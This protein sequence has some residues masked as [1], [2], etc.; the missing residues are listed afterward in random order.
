[1]KLRNLFGI[2]IIMISL[3]LSAQTSG[4]ITIEKKGMRKSYVQNNKAL[5]SKQLASV[6][7]SNQSSARELKASKTNSI[8]GLSSMACGTIFIGVGFYNTIKAAQATNDNDLVG[9]TDYSNKSAGDMLIG[10]GFYVV[11]L[12]FI[13]MSNSHL[14]KSINLYNSANKTGSI[15]KI[16]MNFGFTGTRAMVQLRF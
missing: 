1:M 2:I 6:L 14:K 16:D 3:N 11:S 8:I 15:N 13:I 7:N 10:A 9:S 12:P 4:P 5:D